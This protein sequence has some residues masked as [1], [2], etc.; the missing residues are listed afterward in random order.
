MKLKCRFCKSREIVKYGTRNNKGEKKQVYKCKSCSHKFTMND[1]FLYSKYNSQLITVALDCY[2]R[3]MSMRDTACHLEMLYGKRPSSSTVLEWIRKYGKMTENYTRKLKPKLGSVW[4][5][6]EMNLK[7]NLKENWLWVVEDK[8][9]RYMIACNPTMLRIQKHANATFEQA[10]KLGTPQTVI[11]DG[12]H[13]YPQAI[14]KSFGKDVKHIRSR[15]CAG[16]KAK[17]TRIER[18]NG[19]I[20]QR[21]KVMRGMYNAGTAKDLM[22]AF[23]IHYNFIRPNM[24]LENKTP[25]QAAELNLR[26][27]QDKWKG[28]ISRGANI[29][30]GV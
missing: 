20:R 9:T 2:V 15:G 29:S 27:G 21:E 10:S 5:A 28:L 11:T 16:E 30:N 4:M 17:N 7:F 3:G 18:L 1:G 6:D 23:Q 26:L 14:E 19:T 25:A 8:A 12:L 22:R 13:H 24:A